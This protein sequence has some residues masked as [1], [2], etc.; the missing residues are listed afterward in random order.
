[1]KKIGKIVITVLVIVLTL[2]LVDI[3]AYEL[4]TITSSTGT[5]ET[6]KHVGTSTPITLPDTYETQE[7]DFRGVWISAYVNDVPS[8]STKESYMNAINSVF[9]NMAKHNLNTMV[10]H[11][12][13]SNDAF[14]KS[15]LNPISTYMAGANF[16]EWDP[17]EWIISECHKRGY[18]FHAWMNPYRCA[19]GGVT[20]L[21]TFA[22]KY[23][24]SNIGSDPSKLLLSTS[25]AVILNPGEPLVRNF[26][27]NSCLELVENYDV[28]AIHFDDYFYIEGI[29]DDVTYNKYKHNSDAANVIEWRREQVNLFIEDLSK[30]LNTYNTKNNKTVQLGIAPTGVYRNYRTYVAPEDYVYDSN[31]NLTYPIGSNTGSQEHYGQYLYCDTKKWVDNEWIDYIIPQSYW[32]LEDSVGAYADLMDWWAGV[33]KYKNVN[34][35]SGMGLYMSTDSTRKSWYTSPNEAYNQ[36]LYA[37]QY[38]VIEGH[39]IFS[40]KTLISSNSKIKSRVDNL[41][42]KAWT[43]VA[44]QPEYK[45]GDKIEIG[46]VSNLKYSNTEVG[47]YLEWDKID[48][49]RRYVIYRSSGEVNFT[50]DEVIGICGND[51]GSTINYFDNSSNGTNYNYGVRAMSHTNTLGEGVKANNASSTLSVVF[52]DYDN[53]ILDIKLVESGS[54]VTAPI[55]P[56]REGYKFIGWDKDFTNITEN[57]I[58]KA[59]YEILTFKVIF[60]DDFGNVYKEQIVNYG[61]DAALP[62]SPAIE[63]KE[64]VTWSGSIYNVTE[65]RVVKA[66]FRPIT[67]IVYFYDADGS[68]LSEQEVEHGQSAVAPAEIE[69]L[70]NF[71]KWDTSF[72]SVTETLIITAIYYS[73]ETIIITFKNGNEIVETV[74]I[75]KGEEYPIPTL[76]A[77]DGYTATWSVTDTSTLSSDTIIE[78]V[79]LANVLNVKFYDKD[80]NLLK[81]EQVARGESVVAPTAPTVKGYTFDKW[82]ESLENV[83]SDLVINAIYLENSG[84]NSATFISQLLAFMTVLGIALVGIRRK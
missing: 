50:A 46:K 59:N 18:E 60:T 42:E 35:Y 74:K 6:I 80:G 49:A 16:D 8:Y 25:G 3:K 45:N 38:E 20:N 4:V 12:R 28:D 13:V 22:K 53:S 10:F 14:Y 31:G 15:E 9:E 78:A 37:S 2:C 83:Q 58:V 26:I 77:R 72:D 7:T 67:Y 36:V 33:C 57:L 40:Y 65:D 44:I 39:C 84:C 51:E 62:E 63:G 27:V 5:G 43:T 32:S 19:T 52:T 29:N 70:D 23:P 17:I 1:M 68:E 21:E 24:S 34:L 82:S 79:Y 76:P 61:E 66:V 81:E 64:F 30:K 48:S 73:D 69:I 55:D 11:V 41:L 54:A 47:N 75:D 71:K 56:T